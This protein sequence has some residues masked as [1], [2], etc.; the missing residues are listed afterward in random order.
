VWAEAEEAGGDWKTLLSGGHSGEP[1]LATHRGWQVLVKK[2]A[3]SRLGIEQIELGGGPAL[4]QPKDT[5]GLWGEV[6]ASGLARR[7]NG[8]GV[9]LEKG[10]KG[11]ASETVGG[12]NQKGFSIDPIHGDEGGLWLMSVLS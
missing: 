10:G 3:E 5:F 2:R 11:D 1:L 8:T 12:A 7:R 6:E 9:R 4:G